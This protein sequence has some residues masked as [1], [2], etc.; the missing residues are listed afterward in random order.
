M[1]SLYTWP[2]VP[3]P[4]ADNPVRVVAGPANADRLQVTHI[5]IP[6]FT[7]TY[8]Y[9]YTPHPRNSP[10][11]NITLSI[12]SPDLDAVIQVLRVLAAAP[13]GVCV[14]VCVCAWMCCIIHV[15]L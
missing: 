14:Y 9:T 8:R 12:T 4:I 2:Y 11:N 5:H 13:Y 6:A 3:I 15:V 1:P 10:S 7:Y